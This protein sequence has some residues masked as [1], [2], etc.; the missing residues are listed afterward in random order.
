MSA[1]LERAGG[2][3][4]PERRADAFGV[5]GAV[6]TDSSLHLPAEISFSDYELIGWALGRIRDQSAWALGDWINTGQAIF[7]ERYAAAIEA[8]GRSKGGLMNIASV[9]RRVPRS[10]RRADLSFGHHEAVARFDSQNQARWLEIAAHEGLSVEELRGRLKKPRALG[11]GPNDIVRFCPCCGSEITP[12][13]IIRDQ[14]CQEHG[15]TSIEKETAGLRYF[16]C[17]CFEAIAGAA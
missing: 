8:T 9:A 11:P 12:G 3:L 17:G 10:R 15:R 7:G 16:R 14:V 5:K 2:D 1:E 13:T 6:W 4:L